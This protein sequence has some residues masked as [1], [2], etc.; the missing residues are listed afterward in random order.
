MIN[1][2]IGMG[3]S[4]DVKTA[5][6]E[7]ARNFDNPKFIF[8]CTEFK[9]FAESTK[10]L[11]EM[12]PNAVIIGTTGVTLTQGQVVRDNIVLWSINS[13]VEISANIIENLSKF[14]I[15]SIK[16]IEESIS[17]IN[18]GRDNTVCLEVCTGNEEVLVSTLNS[19]LSKRGIPLIGGTTHGC[20]SDG[21][22]YVYLNGK[23]YKDACAYVLIKNTTGKIKVYKESIYNPKKEK[24]I[25]TKVDINSRR[26]IELN[27]RSAED[28]YCEKLNINKSEIP[29]YNLINPLGRVV[30][31]ETFITAI[32][33]DNNQSGL[34][35][36]KRVN[37]NDVM[38]ILELDDYESIIKNTIEEIKAD[39]NNISCIFSVN[40]ILRYL[41]FENLNYIDKYSKTMS[42][43]GNHFGIISEGEQYINQHINQTMICAVFE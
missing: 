12:Y 3:T 10:I 21:E 23:I 36:Y 7:A 26:I 30:G 15:K 27:G 33:P 16:K 43:M 40:C 9:K 39:F 41:L 38:N 6:K 29:K 4:S 25:A 19:A 35:C 17:N 42:S 22:K 2:Q 32:N 11:G 31:R 28:L 5:V 1:S 14:P 20:S 8:I 24:L 34:K 13:G 18:P 37:Q